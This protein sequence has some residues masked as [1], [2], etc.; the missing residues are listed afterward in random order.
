VLLPQLVLLP[1][2][3]LQQLVLLLL[4]LGPVLV[5]LLVLSWLLQHQLPLPCQLWLCWVC[6]LAPA[7]PA[8]AAAA[9]AAYPQRQQKLMLAKQRLAGVHAVLPPPPPL[10][11]HLARAC[12]VWGPH[13]VQQQLVLVP[14]SLQGP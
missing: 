5:L 13:T 12:H 9:G 8:P 4:L 11:A 2:L 14:D 6:L 7:A 1:T 10:L 3:V